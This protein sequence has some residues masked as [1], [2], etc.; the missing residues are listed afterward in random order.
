MRDSLTWSG[1]SW[2]FDKNNNI[3]ASGNPHIETFSLVLASTLRRGVGMWQWMGLKRLWKFDKLNE[4]LFSKKLSKYCHREI[5]TLFCENLYINAPQKLSKYFFQKS[6]PNSSLYIWR[7]KKVIEIKMVV[8]PDA[9]FIYVTG[10]V[11]TEIFSVR[12]IFI[13][14]PRLGK[15]SWT[16]FRGHW[17]P[18]YSSRFIGSCLGSHVG[19]YRSNRTAFGSA[20]PIPLQLHPWP[21]CRQISRHTKIYHQLVSAKFWGS[22]AASNANVGALFIDIMCCIVLEIRIRKK[23]CLGILAARFWKSRFCTW[24]FSNISNINEILDGRETF[25]H[26]TFPPFCCP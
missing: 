23:R 11:L 3:H 22:R 21:I 19:P 10:P 17:R 26:D 16:Y 1:P 13:Y 2:R 4:T 20:S 18:P 6:C 12:K 25:L 24:F 5:W 15:T 7:K 9:G 14:S 8:L